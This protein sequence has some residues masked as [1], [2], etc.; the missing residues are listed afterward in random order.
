MLSKKNALAVSKVT[1]NTNKTM[2]RETLR[3]ARNQMKVFGDH[4]ERETLQ[5]LLIE[6]PMSVEINYKGNKTTYNGIDI[7]LLKTIT[8]M[9]NISASFTVGE[10]EDYGSVTANGTYYRPFSDILFKTV[11]L[12]I[13]RFPVDQSEPGVVV[14]PYDK[15]KFCFVV[16]KTKG[17]IRPWSI[18]MSF[19]DSV[20]FT[21]LGTY[22]GVYFFFL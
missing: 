8:K 3:K 9:L 17:K 11:D 13:N 22:I 6:H 12:C 2:I 10:Q 20:W 5:V 7:K 19:K 21:M 1:Y 18:T 14:L 15:E 16:K 4:L